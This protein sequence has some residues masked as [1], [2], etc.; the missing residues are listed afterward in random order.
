[1]DRAKL[2]LKAILMEMEEL[3]PDNVKKAEGRK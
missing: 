2:R 1:M 3:L